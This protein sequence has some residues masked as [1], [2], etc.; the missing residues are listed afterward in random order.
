MSLLL[1]IKDLSVDFSTS[2]GTLK[3]VRNLDLT[4]QE[5]EC[6][7]IVGESGSGKS[8]TSL[9][10][11]GLLPSN[12][13]IASGSIVYDGKDLASL[14]QEA[15]RSLRGKEIAMIFQEPGRSFDQL[16][17]IEKTFAETFRAHDK[18]MTDAE[19]RS[20]SLALM[21]EVAISQAASRIKNYPHQFS[22]GML[23]RIMIALALA[24]QPR[25]L[26]ADEPTTALDV[27]I[28]A[29]IVEL[30]QS[31]RKS[32]S[33]SVLFITHNLALLSGFADKITVM[34][35]ALSMESAPAQKLLYT[36]QH[37]YSRFLLNSLIQPGDR[38]SNKVLRE[39][40]GRTPDPLRP[41]P[42]CPFAPRCELAQESCTQ[43]LPAM[44]DG[45]RCPI[46]SNDL[47]LSDRGVK[48]A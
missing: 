39:V 36:P 12:G 16:Y 8:V 47:G 46:V 33:L 26:I 34:Y 43:K 48:N 32:R 22:G 15:M 42:G 13:R 23:Q 9:A 44:I 27:T 11:M 7:G 10:I 25:L 3:A 4:M 28:Q 14:G 17:T 24:N 41:E 37:P 18:H 40:S 20:K 45:L 5:G 38:P 21:D 31:L 19:V 35:S 6:L 2:Q 1:E 29:Q 30:I